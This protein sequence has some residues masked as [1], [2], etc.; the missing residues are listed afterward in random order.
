PGEGGAGPDDHPS[1]GRIEAYDVQRLALGPAV[2]ESETTA[3]PHGEAGNPFVPA[4][5]TPVDVD[6]L[7][8]LHRLRPQP[9]QEGNVSAR[10]HEA[11]V[12]AV[13]LRGHFEA[14]T[15]GQCARFALLQIAQRE[16]Q[17][18]ELLAGGRE[19]EIA[20]VAGRLGRPV[21]LGTVR[22][23]NP[24]NVVP[25]HEGV[26]AEVAGR[27]HQVA[28]LDP[29]VAPDAGDRGRTRQ[30]GLDEIVDHR[31]AKAALVVED[32]VRNPQ[33]VR[34]APSI[35]DVLSGATGALLPGRR[36]VVVELQGDADD[37]VAFRAQQRGRRRAV[38]AAGHGYHRPRA[39]RRL[40]D[41]EGVHGREYRRSGRRC[42][43]ACSAGGRMEAH[44]PEG[45]FQLG[46]LPEGLHQILE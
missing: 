25:R 31:L 36:T 15:F 2:T 37:I 3:L 21:Q 29:L 17:E 22:S 32:I 10:R 4:E 1:L 18:I 27:L 16:A 13:R 8:G 24:A 19:Q 34:H 26:A 20:L 23:L 42:N 41:S 7:A 45:D 30:V 9:V 43:D 33:P 39:R 12:L 35:V 11:D 40:V 14:E 44:V 46:R 38:D 5:Y 28:K 6:D